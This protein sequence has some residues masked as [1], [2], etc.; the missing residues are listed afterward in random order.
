MTLDTRLLRDA[1]QKTYTEVVRDP[2]KGYHFHTGPDY[3]A[4]R[5]G[6]RGHLARQ[7]LHRRLRPA[8]G[9]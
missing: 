3:A 8:Q 4:E 6:R 1:I 9:G 7:A 2:K 5:L